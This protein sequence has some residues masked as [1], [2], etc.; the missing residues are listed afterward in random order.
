[1]L[2][3]D[4]IACRTLATLAWLGTGA[5]FLA[6]MVLSWGIITFSAF[7]AWSALAMPLAILT[8]HWLRRIGRPLEAR[9][10]RRTAT[11]WFLVL[12]ADAA[13]FAF[14]GRVSGWAGSAYIW[15]LELACIACPAGI[16]GL[17]LQEIYRR[18]AVRAA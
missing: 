17:A 8:W 13:F 1:M 4:S 12:V 18:K 14:D 3:T 9:V 5:V 6:I 10:M 15:S 7:L 2:G 16:T 11:W